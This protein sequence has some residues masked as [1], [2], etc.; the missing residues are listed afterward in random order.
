MSR[1]PSGNSVPWPEL[2]G[3]RRRRARVGY[4]G[5]G[6]GTSDARFRALVA[7]GGGCYEPPTPYPFDDGRRSTPARERVFEVRISRRCRISI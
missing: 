7:L 1:K 6:A 5:G 3:K 2:P 4:H